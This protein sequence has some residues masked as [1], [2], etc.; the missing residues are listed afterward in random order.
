[1]SLTVLVADDEVGI[2]RSLS[3]ALERRGYGV[4]SSHTG[5][6]V[7]DIMSQRPIDAVLLDL[8]LPGMSGCELARLIRQRCG[9]DRL[10]LVALTGYGQ[11]SDRQATREAGF[12]AHLTKPLKPGELY[13]TLN[14]LLSNGDNVSEKASSPAN[15]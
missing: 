8:G 10:R 5:G 15:P 12:D 6:G 11:A 14:A 3:R 4:E 7:L 13:R 2:V 1:M 9:P